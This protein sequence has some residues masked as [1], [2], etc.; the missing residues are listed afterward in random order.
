MFS[1]A[2]T[3]FDFTQELQLVRRRQGSKLT[4]VTA[5]NEQEDRFFSWMNET[6]HRLSGLQDAE[7]EKKLQVKWS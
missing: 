7:D 6:E 1:T 3:I 2:V 4:P 5:E